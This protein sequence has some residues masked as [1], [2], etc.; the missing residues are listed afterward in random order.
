M[1]TTEKGKDT[2]IACYHCGDDCRDDSIKIDDKVFCCNGCKAV[3]ELLNANNMCNYYDI[4]QNPGQTISKPI[5]KSKYDFLDDSSLREKLIDFSDGNITTVSFYIPQMHCSS[6]IWL[7]E[8]LYKLDEGVKHSQADFLKKT[9]S[10]KFNENEISIRRLV[11]LLDSIGY[12]PLLNLDAAEQKDEAKLNKSLYYKIGVA[13]FCFGNIMLLSFPEYLSIQ[14]IVQ[15]NLR[16]LFGYVILFLALPVFFYS[17]SEY[18]ISAYK[19]LRKKIINIDVPVT[20]GISVIFIRSLYEIVSG[21][22]PGFFDSMSALVFFL[23]AGR[24]FQNKTYDTLNFERNY[25]SYFPISVT[26]LKNGIETTKP[27]ENLELNDRI[28][29]RNNEL[30]PA[31]AVLMKG[32]AHIDYSFVTGESEPVGRKIGDQV[33]AGGKQKGSAIELEVVKEVSQS[34]LTRLWN[35]DSFKKTETKFNNLSDKVSQYFTVVILLIAAAVF[36]YWIGTDPDIAINSVSAVLIVACPCALA[37]SV[38]FTFGNTMRIFSANKFYVKNTGIIEKLSGINSVVFDKTGTITETGHS[39]IEFTGADLTGLELAGIKT[40]LNNSSHPLSRQLTA[41]IKEETVKGIDEFE[42]FPGKGIKGKIGSNRYALGSP[43]L[44]GASYTEYS[45]IIP[46][47]K[48]FVKIN[49]EIKGFFSLRN[50]YREGLEEIADDLGKRYK[51]SIL[52]GDNDNEKKFLSTFFNPDTEMKFNQSPGDKLQFIK[53]LQ[54]ENKN[55][56]MIGDGLNDAGALKASDVGI[57]ITEDINNFSPACDAILGA[58]NF[59]NLNK[60]ILFSKTSVR[61]IIFSFIISFIYNIAGLTFAVQGELSPVIAA[62]LMPL[63]SISVVIF[64][65]FATTII[66]R[67]RRLL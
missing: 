65:T 12:E 8:N 46:S 25:K 4:Q 52:S 48:V 15:D 67:K 66:A 27:L 2:K 50:K 44:V 32:D 28:I 47:S 20:L 42:E 37:L 1:I 17:A 38:P 53:S 39:V 29:V 59:R 57:S 35:D 16:N 41:F 21:T 19:G 45:E 6:C 10:V 54:K 36:L 33:Y 14:D 56:L 23:L 9:L 60:Y 24:L 7:L 49:E 58:E 43:D 13:G 34:Y 18:Y 3:Y 51:L 63:S 5:P 11:E 31:D 61:I 40:L 64:T 55:V 22:G 26:I 62:I 30:I